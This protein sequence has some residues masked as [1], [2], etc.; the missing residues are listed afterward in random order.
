MERGSKGT[1][2]GASSQRR[3]ACPFWEDEPFCFANDSAVSLQ[4]MINELL[5]GADVVLATNSGASPEGPLK[6]VT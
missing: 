6:S 4:R 2:K 5:K 1:E 3:G